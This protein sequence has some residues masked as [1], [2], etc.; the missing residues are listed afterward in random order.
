MGKCR[1]KASIICPKYTIVTIVKPQIYTSQ[2]EQKHDKLD[3]KTTCD[4]WLF[5]R[6]KRRSDFMS[7]WAL[8]HNFCLN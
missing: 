5:L 4:L 2:V 7:L 3:Q 6:G 8:Q 1:G